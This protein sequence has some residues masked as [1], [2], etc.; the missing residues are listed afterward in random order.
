[1]QP[2]GLQSATGG[3]LQSAMGVWLQNTT[4]GIAKCDGISKCDIITIRNIYPKLAI[5][6]RKWHYFILY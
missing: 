3:R 1:M 6:T 5:K 2:K 4:K